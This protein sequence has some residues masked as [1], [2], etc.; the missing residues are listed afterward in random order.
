M[1]KPILGFE[2]I[3]ID[4]G[5]NRTLLLLHG[6]GGDEKDL[7]P[8]G[9]A[10]DDQANILSPRG[11]VSENGALRFFKRLAE[12]VLDRDDLKLRSAELGEF[13]V[14]CSK[15]YHFDLNEVWAVGF[16]NGANIALNLLATNPKVLSKAILLRPTSLT[17]LPDV[18]SNLSNSLALVLSGVAD[19][20]VHLGDGQKIA[21]ALS[22]AGAEV[23]FHELPA[24]HGLTGQDIKH[25]KDWLA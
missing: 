25:A 17:A 11:K 1:N 8:I 16:S 14:E 3:Y 21:Q 13:L 20:M 6:T 12:G 2:H 18:V 10:L 24:G 19:T 7:L 22:V 15:I 23:E 4:H 9:Q 5:S